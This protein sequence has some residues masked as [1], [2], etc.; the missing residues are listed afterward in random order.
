MTRTAVLIGGSGYVG[1]GIGRALTARGFAV[2]SVG[3]AR[4]DLLA[5]P[6]AELT[7]LLACADLVVNAAGALWRASDR[8]MADS[9][10]VLVR[11]LVEA[12]DAM[13]RPVPLIH[14]GSAYEYGVAQA[15]GARGVDEPTP[16]RPV[17]AY[18]R[19]K[20][21][22]TECLS[23]WGGSAVVLRCSTVIG[24]GAPRAS[25]FG[26]VAHRLADLAAHPGAR[27]VLELPTLRG[28][29]D[30]LDLRDLGSAVLAAD[31]WLSRHPA[32]GVDIVNIASGNPVRVDRAVQRLIEL[33]A[34]RVRV[35][36]AE[37]PNVS[38]G[39]ANGAPR[40]RITK[41]AQ[42]LGW[43]PRFGVDDALHAL[44]SY[45]SAGL[46]RPNA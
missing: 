23:R 31:R 30:V 42:T 11:R 40:I 34:L 37:R 13:A 18:G 6:V 26:S 46:I 7:E 10:V 41:A 20:L 4:F 1:G 44:W 43:T 25:L 21:A 9:N 24:A 27:Q 5:R 8:E 19:T 2:V 45:T 14:I 36:T 35:V 32:P 39:S 15:G 29:V 33:S 16:P 38:G 22:A 3:R 28:T 12:I 17:S